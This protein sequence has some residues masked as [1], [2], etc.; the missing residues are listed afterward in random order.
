MKLEPEQFQKIAECFPVQRGN[1]SLSNL[2]VL[3]AILHVMENDGKWRRLPKEFGNWHTIY[4][5]MNRWHRNGTLD[6][7]FKKLQELGFLKIRMEI[8]D[9][10]QESK[11]EV[12][13]EVRLNFVWLP[14]LLEP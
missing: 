6:R 14:R 8:V 1:V 13:G 7:V 5:R 4:V 11:M 9:R 2:D 12:K 10:Q 3:N